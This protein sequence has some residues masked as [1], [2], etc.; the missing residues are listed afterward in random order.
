[1]NPIDFIVLGILAVLVFLAI[2]YSVKH[3]GNGCSG[4]SGCSVQ[5]CPH[6]QEAPADRP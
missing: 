6:R 5:N 3:K 2:R 4:C 1:M